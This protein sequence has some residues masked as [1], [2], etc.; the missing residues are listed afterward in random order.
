[1]RTAGPQRTVQSPEVSSVKIHPLSSDYCVTKDG[2]IN[3]IIRSVVAVCRTHG[4]R[5]CCSAYQT[6]GDT[7][8]RNTGREGGAAVTAM[9]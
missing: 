4:E 8:R 5:N 2:R 7:W 3:S 9:G 6:Y 1:M